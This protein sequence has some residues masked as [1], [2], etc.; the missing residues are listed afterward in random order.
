MAISLVVG[1]MDLR[2]MAVVTTA[3]TAE[4]IAPAGIRV[5][6]TIGVVVV[7]AG[8]VLIVRAVGIG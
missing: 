6:R 1:V 8:L 5:A 4:R 3:I 7:T 2:V